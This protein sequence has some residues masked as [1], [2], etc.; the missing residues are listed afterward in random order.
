MKQLEI[1]DTTLRDGAQ[2]SGISFSVSDKH[3]LIS[4]IDCFGIDCIE[5][6]NPAYNPKD[7]ELFE[8]LR[9]EKRK[10]RLCAFVSTCK[11]GEAA[12]QD[13]GLRKTAECGA[14]CVSVVGKA[15]YTHIKKI[16][17]TGRR[18]NLRIITDSVRYFTA[19]NIPVIFYAEHFFDGC[20]EMPQTAFDVVGAAFE[21][22]ADCVV[23]CD[24]NGG[25]LPAEVG[26]ITRDTLSRFPGKKFGIHCHNDSG[27]AVA[28][29]LS[30]VEAGATQI[31]GTFLGLGERCGNA[32]LSTL[33]PILTLKMGYSLVCGENLP[34]LTSL[35]RDI[36]DLA[37]TS[38]DERQP[39]VGALAFSHKAGMH[40]D[41]VKKLP[42]SFEHIDPAAVGNERKNVIGEFS[43]KSAIFEK[44]HS[45][46]PT[47]EKNS[48]VVSNFLK[49]I[50][51]HEKE[52][53]FYENADASLKLEILRSLGK[54]RSFFRLLTFK[55]VLGEPNITNAEAAKASALIKIEVNGTEEITAAEG[56]GPVNAMD[57]ALRK[58]LKR[59]YP[60]IENIKLVDYKVRVLDSAGA[61]GA[62]VRVLIETSDGRTS[63][64]TVGVSTD[65]MEAS[66][67]AL[68]DS[69][70]Y[71]LT[72]KV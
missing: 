33:I 68:I 15:S 39:F 32:S 59:F 24:T 66:W 70:E 22:G 21:A 7:G 31:H 1:F 23:L 56:N 43:G 49:D 61:T 25:S 17:K 16:L 41:A 62:K 2:A 45:L 11:V 67:K 9:N 47:L 71:F 54:R 55:L 18:E 30:A 58:A 57:N 4:L 20:K 42:G 69:V 28:C 50:K 12:E 65:I 34:R 64:H 8:L 63:W 52:G 53:Y 5:A 72:E 3:K 35:S 19:R 38:F 27:L 40:I 26:S 44:M 51:A 10:S 48:P 36:A 6:G 13:E 29:T 60:A 46:E 37:N 14:D